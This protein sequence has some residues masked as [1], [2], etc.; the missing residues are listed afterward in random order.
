MQKIA[1]LLG[2]V[3]L[4]SCNE[5]LIEKPENLIDKEKMAA[6]YYDL[7]LLTSGKN[8]NNQVLIN[9]GIETM[10][11]IFVK[12]GIDSLQFVESDI[13][14]ASNALVYKEIYQKAESK[15]QADVDAFEEARKAEQKRDSILKLTTTVKIDSLTG[16]II[17][18]N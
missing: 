14:Y 6:I 17:E 10:N 7:A 9:E 3:M 1:F 8:T 12:Y 16:E 18:D 11:F 2:V 5:K 13:F 15:L 4:F